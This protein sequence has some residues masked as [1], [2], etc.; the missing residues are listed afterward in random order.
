[1]KNNLE[2]INTKL[3][4]KMHSKKIQKIIDKSEIIVKKNQTA[5]FKNSKNFTKTLVNF[6]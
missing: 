5:I 1:M 4:Q 2:V 3:I 6:S